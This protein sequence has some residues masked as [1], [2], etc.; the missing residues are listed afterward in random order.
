MRHGEGDH[1]IMHQQ[2]AA[3]RGRAARHRLLFTPP[4]RL[5]WTFRSRRALI[6]PYSEPPPDPEMIRQQAAAR[7]VTATRSWQQA[8]KWGIRPSLIIIIGLIAL[9][10]CAH[11]VSGT[12]P[13]GTTILIALVLAGPGLGWSVWQYAQYKAARTTDPRTTDPGQ[14]YQQAQREWAGRAADHERAEL[15]RAVR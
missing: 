15:D 5:G 12:A 13:F 14:Q 9:A 7:L 8:K 3:P 10:G 4:V 11:A 6:T 2:P 1:A